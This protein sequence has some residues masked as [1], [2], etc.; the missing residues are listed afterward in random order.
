VQQESVAARATLNRDA[1]SLAG[2]I[3]TRV[4]GR[5]S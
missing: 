2:A 4:L 5:A 3:V 1:S